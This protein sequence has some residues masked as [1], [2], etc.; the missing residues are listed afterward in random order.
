MKKIIVNGGEFYKLYQV[1]SA[2]KNFSANAQTALFNVRKDVIYRIEVDNTTDKFDLYNGQYLE[3]KAASRLYV[4][5]NKAIF[6]VRAYQ[7]G[8][9]YMRYANAMTGINIVAYE[10]EKYD[11]FV[12]TPNV[13]IA[14]SLNWGSY[15]IYVQPVPEAGQTYH[16]QFT[17]NYNGQFALYGS[18]NA[19]LIN[20]TT[21]TEGQ[22][23]ELDYTAVA[24][25]GY[26]QVR[27]FA[28]GNPIAV[29][30]NKA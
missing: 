19:V 18:N 23:F 22:T 21:C 2:T 24:D 15:F 25:N 13:A 20:P 14:Y 11:K 30:I 10:V 16:C 12:V 7:N 4:S 29:K 28:S 9:L 3:N 1:Y 6:T 8:T 17:T 26:M 5:N 27:S